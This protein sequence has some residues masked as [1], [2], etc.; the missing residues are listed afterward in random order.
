MLSGENSSICHCYEQIRVNYQ[1]L[2]HTLRGPTGLT[3]LTML[4]YKSQLAYRFICSADRTRSEASAIPTGVPE[5]H[6][7][8]G[9]LYR[10]HAEGTCPPA[11]VSPSYMPGIRSDQ[12]SS[13]TISQMN[14]TY[15]FHKKNQPELHV[16][17]KAP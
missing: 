7:V 5:R 11:P 6:V 9:S 4:P 17:C 13:A 3:K 8:E 1:W 16:L 2:L 10:N 14:K 15:S 12:N